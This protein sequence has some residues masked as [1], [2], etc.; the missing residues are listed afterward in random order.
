MSIISAVHTHTHTVSLSVTH[1][2]FFLIQ[3]TVKV[4]TDTECVRQLCYRVLLFTLT[5]PI[6]RE[7]GQGRVGGVM[8]K[9]QGQ[10]RSAI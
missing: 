8:L 3:V 10:G 4:Q 2:P 6:I 5:P 9:G 7:V 1:S